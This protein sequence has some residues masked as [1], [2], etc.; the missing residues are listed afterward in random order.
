MGLGELMPQNYMTR[1]E[2]PLGDGEPLG[3]AGAQIVAVRLSD[4]AKRSEH[5]HRIRVDVGEGRYRIFVAGDF[6]ARASAH[7]AVSLRRRS[8]GTRQPRR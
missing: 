1:Y 3:M 4:L 6:A 7:L 2:P 8:G 5:G